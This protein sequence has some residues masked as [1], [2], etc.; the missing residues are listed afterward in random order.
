MKERG[1]LIRH[2]AVDYLRNLSSSLAPALG[3]FGEDFHVDASDGIGRKTE[4]PWVRFCSRNMSPK[5]TQGYYCVLHFSTDGSAVYLAIGCSSSK[6]QNGSFITLSD[7][8]LDRRT[9]WARQV[10]HEA[11]GSLEPF[12]D[13]PDYGATRPLPISFQRATAMAK[14]VEVGQLDEVDLDGLLTQAAHHLKF[15]YQAEADGRELSPAD[16]DELEIIQTMRPKSSRKGQGYGLSG[17]ERKEVETRAMFLV[18]GWLEDKGYRVK[19]TSSN[20][21]YDFEASKDGSTMKVEVKGTTSDSSDAILMTRNEVDLHQAEKGKTALFIV[22]SIRLERGSAGP[23]ATGG[24]IEAFLGWDI[25][26]WE[27]TSTAYRVGRPTT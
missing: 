12:T 15:I 14:R 9:S 4:L 16:M 27:L 25:D 6:F 22:S 10:V 21:P 5:P 23:S 8:D 7:D 17:E 11:H 2:D 3:K 26:K 13:S 18:K 20:R 1:Q 24:V 19:D